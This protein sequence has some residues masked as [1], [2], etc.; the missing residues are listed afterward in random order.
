MLR[1]FARG[2]A[3]RCGYEILGPPRAFAAHRSLSGLLQ[4]ERINLVLDVGANAGQ[5]VDELRRAGYSGRIVSFEPL[6]SAHAVL[7]SRAE[8]DPNWTI[9][10]RTAIGAE[11]GSV[12]INISRNGVSSS[13]LDMLPSHAQ[14]EPQSSYVGAETVPVHR[15]D[16]LCIV[17][18]TDRTILKI[19]VQ[20][21]ERQVL[22]GAQQVL[23]QCRAVI[24]EMSLVPLYDG[25]MLAKELWGLL[26]AQGFEPWA[27]EPGFRNP[28]T[29]RMLQIDGIFVRPQGAPQ[30]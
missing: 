2:L 7:R 8:R 28:G 23:S 15:L 5:F 21:Y 16:D 12:Q 30:A 26:A 13:I 3:R 27:F 4:Q 10:D 22:A 11:K 20:G 24:A 18:S 9:A 25:Q 1:R 6:A 29:G 19:D 17:D 14:A